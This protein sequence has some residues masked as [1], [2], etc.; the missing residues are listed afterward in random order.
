MRECVWGE[1]RILSRADRMI[2]MH[3]FATVVNITNAPDR[4]CTFSPHDV[5]N[6]DQQR[7]E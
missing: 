6:F 4:T 1:K 7:V 5:G 3:V 2:S